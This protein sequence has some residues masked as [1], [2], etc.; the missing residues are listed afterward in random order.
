MISVGMKHW[1]R[2]WNTILIPNLTQ[3]EFL[4]PSFIS[5][6]IMII[7]MMS[8]RIFEFSFHWIVLLHLLGIQPGCIVVTPTGK[9][10]AVVLSHLTLALAGVCT[11]LWC[12]DSE[13]LL[14]YQ[15]SL[16]AKLP[17]SHEI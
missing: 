2:F 17:G 6:V 1:S 10:L 12:P 16:M 14:W 13:Y 9:M 4:G 11:G 7:I 3:V 5:I 15:G 8:V